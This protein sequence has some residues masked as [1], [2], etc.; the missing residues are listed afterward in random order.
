M[1]GQYGGSSDRHEHPVA[2]PKKQRDDSEDDE[3]TYV[4]EQ[5]HDTISKEDYAKML[6]PES[7]KPPNATEG[8]AGTKEDPS[9]HDT[10]TEAP[11]KAVEASVGNK[12]RR[13]AKA[14]GTTEGEPVEDAADRPKKTAKKAGKKTQKVKLSFDDET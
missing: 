1:K 4:D 14:V 13:L 2:R 12:K 8:G 10:A 5:S 6:N 11:R 9:N 7:E 3:P